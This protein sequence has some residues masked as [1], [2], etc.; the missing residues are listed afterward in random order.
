MTFVAT[1]GVGALVVVVAFGPRSSVPPS[2]PS[3][4]RP[5]L[6]STP[7]VGPTVNA[8]GLHGHGQLAFVSRGELYVLDGTTKAL[9]QVTEGSPLP[10]S[11][12]FSHD[13]KWLAFV[14]ATTG[15]E[16]GEAT[17]WIAHGDGTDAHRVAQ[18]PAAYPA[19]NSGSPLFSW[20]PS[21][22]E[23]L[24]TTGPVTGTPLVPRE[25]WIVP[26]SGSAHRLLGPG[27]TTGAVWSPDGSEVAVLWS[28][29]GLSTQVLETLPPSGG[30]PTVWLPVNSN[31]YYLAGWSSRFG[32][33]VWYD[34][35][36]GGPSVENYGLPLG[37]FSQPGA[38]LTVLATTPLFQPPALAIGPQGQ[39]DVVANGN[40]N[41]GGGEGEKFVW[42]GKTV[43]TCSPVSDK[44]SAA[45]EQ[46]SSVTLDP[47]V[48]TV[49][50]SLAFVE[51]PQSTEGL[52]P[53]Y[54][55][56]STW[57]QI[58]GWYA[59]HTLWIAPGGTGRPREVPGTTGAS[60]PVWSSLGPGLVYAA[61]GELWYLPSSNAQPVEVASPLASPTGST[62]GKYLFGYADWSG[63]FAWTG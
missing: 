38:T 20:N 21:S 59:A 27:Y 46:T 61:N 12:A 50:G 47:A 63:E 14:R 42:F 24:V 56:T 19:P 39:L 15:S 8:A 40:D 17:L 25:I 54:S 29:N 44:C 6:S 4:S 26:A 9:H 32:I 58:S 57:S 60:D 2:G 1:A 3:T 16:Q 7:T 45:I 43:E 23:L 11:P 41:D 30:T 55:P 62:S 35:G 10:S 37:A 48:S 22:D 5:T 53:D 36:N 33:L 13:G 18:V 51:A 31:T 52:P 34:Q 28:S 49:D